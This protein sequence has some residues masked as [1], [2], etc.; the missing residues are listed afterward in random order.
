M[1][2]LAEWRKAGVAVATAVVEVVAVWQGAPEWA[3][4]AAAGA[5]AAL[6]WLVPNRTGV[7]ALPALASGELLE[8]AEQAARREERAA[9][10]R[11]R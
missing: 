1:S 8:L 11:R 9:A 5:G 2:R 3:L 7:G 6:V 10:E 4:M